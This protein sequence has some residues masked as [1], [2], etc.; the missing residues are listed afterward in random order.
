[1]EPS[2]GFQIDKGNCLADFRRSKER[3]STSRSFGG[4][5]KDKIGV[6][7]RQS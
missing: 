7:E 3:E 6:E 5:G 1:M 2:R 4:T